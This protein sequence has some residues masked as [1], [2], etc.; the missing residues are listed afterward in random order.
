MPDTRNGAALL[1]VA[2]EFRPRILAER[3]DIETSRRVPEHVTRDLAR[4]GF[5]RIFLP[6]AY[7]GLDLTPMEGAEIFEELARADASVAWCVFNGNTHWTVPMHADPNVVTANSTRPSGQAQI[8]AM[9]GLEPDTPL[10]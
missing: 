7:S 6:S 1:K 10:L 4:A 2:R 8:V 5:F 3:D 9:F